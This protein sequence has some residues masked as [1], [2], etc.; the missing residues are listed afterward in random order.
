MEKKEP[1]EMIKEALASWVS[2]NT[3]MKTAGENTCLA[4]LEYE[5]KHRGRQAMIDRI[6]S[7]YNRVRRQREFAELKQYYKTRI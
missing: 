6:Y 7:R 2:L 1:I 5:K 3:A 4:M